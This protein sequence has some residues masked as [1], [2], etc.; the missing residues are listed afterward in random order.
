MEEF[1]G[2]V[3][4]LKH[5]FAQAMNLAKNL[6][7]KNEVLRSILKENESK[8]N[9]NLNEM[10]KAIEDLRQKNMMLQRRLNICLLYTSDAA[11]E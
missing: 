11:D 2:E 5:N 9:Y 4:D 10:E 8:Y 6:I 1:H 3:G 7:A